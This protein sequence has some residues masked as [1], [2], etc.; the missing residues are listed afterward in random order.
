MNNPIPVITVDGPSGS[1]K[2]TISQ[3]LARE[4]NW[5]FLD[6]GALY[7]VLGLAA[8]NHNVPFND[9]NNL[10]ILAA[11]LDVKFIAKQIGDDSEI[12]L[13]DTNVSTIIRSPEIGNIASQIAAFPAVRTALVQKQCE[14]RQMPGL[15]ADGR[16]MGST[17]FPDAQPKVFL[18]ASAEE[19]ARRRYVQL[20]EKG[21]N[22]S[23]A[24]VLAELIERDRR[25]TERSASPLQP[26]PDA[27]I[28]D[29]THLTI[30]EVFSRII[31]RIK[32]K[33]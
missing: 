8:R 21:I 31:H 25:D 33:E 10:A 14:F 19:R 9:E 32:Y 5:H 28:I 4:L 7:R 26:A 29:T 18:I 24:Q 30:D 22:V 1:G 6:S 23:L 12:I 16:D 2:G 11:N 17:I 20:Q 13:E 3:L 27:W 15:V